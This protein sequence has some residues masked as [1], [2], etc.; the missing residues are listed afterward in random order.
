[1]FQIIY[2]SSAHTSCSRIS[3]L[4]HYIVVIIWTTPNEVQVV[5]DAGWHWWCAGEHSLLSQVL[6]RGWDVHTGWHIWHSW[7][8]CPWQW[9]K[10]ALSSKAPRSKYLN[11]SLPLG[12]SFSGSN[13]FW[14]ETTGLILPSHRYYTWC[15]L[16]C[17][18][19]CEGVACG[20]H[21]WQPW[22]HWQ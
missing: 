7:Q 14:T 1:M 4:C 18:I 15:L 16:R 21:C 6:W 13:P 20:V 3:R 9:K 22:S 10:T 11:K 17:V 2:F 5:C 19:S 8:P 12:F